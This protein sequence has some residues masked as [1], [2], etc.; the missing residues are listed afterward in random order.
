M[1]ERDAQ[2]TEFVNAY[3]AARRQRGYIA[4]QMFLLALDKCSYEV[5]ITALEQHKRSEQWQREPRFIPSLLTWLQQEHWIR[6]LPEPE[7][8]PNRRT[9]F[10]QARHDGLKK[11]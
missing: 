7:A 5:L 6:V 9:P 8:A 4:E 1:I 11:W 10:E 2:F 3:P